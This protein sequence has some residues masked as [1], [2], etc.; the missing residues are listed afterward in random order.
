METW[1]SRVPVAAGFSTI[2]EAE[3]ALKDAIIHLER[4]KRVKVARLRGQKQDVMQWRV[5][6]LA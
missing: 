2:D 4:E 1:F 5:R 3:N 6:V